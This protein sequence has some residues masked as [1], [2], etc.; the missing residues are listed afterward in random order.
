M[1]VIDETHYIHGQWYV[2]LPADLFPQYKGGNVCATLLR[3][4][5][6]PQ[7]W[8][9]HMRYRYYVD[10]KAHDSDDV[11]HGHMLRKVCDED[12]AA[13]G[14]MSGMEQIANKF[15]GIIQFWEVKGDVMKMVRLSEVAPASWM[16]PKPA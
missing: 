6:E 16:N 10:Q 15:G 12:E 11:R 9:L 3:K 4:L 14:A 7:N 1:L 8:N 2:E 13:R 5:D